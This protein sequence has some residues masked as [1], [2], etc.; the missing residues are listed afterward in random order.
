MSRLKTTTDAAGIQ[1]QCIELGTM[2]KIFVKSSVAKAE[3]YWIHMYLCGSSR[4]QV[5]PPEVR[6]I[7]GLSELAQV[8]TDLDGSM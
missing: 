3:P 5:N 1:L 4:V 6:R 2:W 7:S 8:L